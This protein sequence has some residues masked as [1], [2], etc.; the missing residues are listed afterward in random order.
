MIAATD[1]GFAASAAGSAPLRRQSIQR[2][3]RSSGQ[4]IATRNL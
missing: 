3:G 1:F 4:Y 2:R